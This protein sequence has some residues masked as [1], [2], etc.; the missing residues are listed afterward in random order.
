MTCLWHHALCTDCVQADETVAL[1]WVKSVSNGRQR[2]GPTPALQQTQ[3][4]HLRQCTPAPHLCG[5]TQ[6]P[7]PVRQHFIQVHR[8]CDHLNIQQPK[9]RALRHQLAVYNDARAAVKVE[10][11]TITAALRRQGLAG[12]CTCTCYPPVE[13]GKAKACVGWSNADAHGRSVGA[14]RGFVWGA[15]GADAHGRSM[16]LCGESD[17]DAHGQSV[18]LCVLHNCACCRA[19][20]SAPACAIVSFCVDW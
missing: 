5:P 7:T 9:L 11:A 6:S 16:G 18:G 20:D 2:I 14:E 17:A 3:S 12:W 13:G 19:I 4:P 10:P 1:Y 15:S 8:R